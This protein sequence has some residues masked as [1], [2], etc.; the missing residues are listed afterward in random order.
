M[1]TARRRWLAVALAAAGAAVGASLARAQNARPPVGEIKP[2]GRDRFQIGRIV[3]DK[4]ARRFVVPGRVHL[5]DVPLEYLATSPGGV[6]AYETLLELDTTGSEFNLACILVGLE[7]DTRPGR[8]VPDPDQSMPGQRVALSLAWGE[9]SQRRQVTAA[10]ALLGPGAETRPETVEWVYTGAPTSDGQP[11]FAAD[12]TGT[13]IAFK[14][15]GNAV[16]ESAVSI[17]IGAY[18]SIRGTTLLPP[19]GTAIE[20]IVEAAPAVPAP[21]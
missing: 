14:R 15:D 9:G 17:G 3:V 8:D 7:R 20:L 1:K 6:K 4:P 18:G 5:L 16:I 21:R 12:V 19:V 13:L 2:L 10:Q 11:R